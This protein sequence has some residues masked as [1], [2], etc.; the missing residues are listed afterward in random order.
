[1]RCWSVVAMSH[2]A[3][4]PHHILTLEV[5]SATYP[6][7]PKTSR[8]ASSWALIVWSSG[9][10]LSG[11]SHVGSLAAALVPLRHGSQAPPTM[12]PQRPPRSVTLVSTRLFSL[13]LRFAST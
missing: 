9:L 7:T 8:I 1:M 5:V 2:M 10:V 13:T 3:R 6:S 12:I 11:S 4:D